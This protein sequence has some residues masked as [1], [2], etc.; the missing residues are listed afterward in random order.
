MRG[1]KTLANQC[2]LLLS[3]FSRDGGWVRENKEQL[4]VSESCLCEWCVTRVRSC[5]YTWQHGT[6]SLSL[7]S[8]GTT[9]PPPPGPR[10]PPRLIHGAATLPKAEAPR[11][12]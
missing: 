6:R 12:G 8:P 11:E 2:K 4:E 3:Q 5:R 9:S 7:L 10:R 1:E